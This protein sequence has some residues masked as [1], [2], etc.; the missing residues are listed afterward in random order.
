VD[1]GIRHNWDSIVDILSRPQVWQLRH[2]SFISDSGRDFSLLPSSHASVGFHPDSCSVGMEVAWHEADHSCPFTVVLRLCVCVCVC[3]WTSTLLNACMARTGTT[4]QIPECNENT[5]L[6]TG[7]YQVQDRLYHQKYILHFH[8]KYIKKSQ[9]L[10]V[11][12][13]HLLLVTL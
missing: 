4:L 5:D 8:G 9:R 10:T 12:A 3:S 2:H 13:R 1:A 6:D 7:M 11:R